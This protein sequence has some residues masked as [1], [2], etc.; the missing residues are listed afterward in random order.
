MDLLKMEKA[1]RLLTKQNIL[2]AQTPL[3]SE[4]KK[5]IHLREE[6]YERKWKGKK[7]VHLESRKAAKTAHKFHVA[8]D[9]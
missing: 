7:M 4:N 2:T 5:K 3:S 9:K 1:G 8:D 6:L